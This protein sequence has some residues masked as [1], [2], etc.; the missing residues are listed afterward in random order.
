M[1]DK[2][3]EQTTLFMYYCIAD[4]NHIKRSCSVYIITYKCG[5]ENHKDNQILIEPPAEIADFFK[6][7]KVCLRLLLR[8]KI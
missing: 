7:G 3:V 6:S 8:Y 4:K 5:L 2:K 1:S